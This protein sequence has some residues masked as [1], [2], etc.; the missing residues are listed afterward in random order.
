MYIILTILR[1]S[2]ANF[3]QQPHFNFHLTWGFFS[4]LT[5]QTPLWR[6]ILSLVRSLRSLETIFF[7]SLSVFTLATKLRTESFIYLHVQRLNDICSHEM[8]LGLEAENLMQYVGVIDELQCLNKS[9]TI[10]IQHL[11]FNVM[12][13]SHQ[14]WW[15]TGKH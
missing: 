13:I 10:L 4:P 9:E 8:P 11:S 14:E 6:E 7:S 2:G 1:I 15:N 3:K 5:P 12:C